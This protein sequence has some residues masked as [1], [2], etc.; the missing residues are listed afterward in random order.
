M[1]RHRLVIELSEEQWKEL[2]VIDWGVKSAVFRIIINDLI[3]AM[4]RHGTQE[5]IGLILA[6]KISVSDITGLTEEE[7]NHE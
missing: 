7:K 6:K 5:I 4:K 2:N 1:T 3:K